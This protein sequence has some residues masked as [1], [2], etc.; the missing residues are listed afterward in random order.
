M[1]KERINNK[2]ENKICNFVGIKACEYEEWKLQFQQIGESY[3]S[4]FNT[5]G[6]RNS[7]SNIFQ[8]IYKCNPNRLENSFISLRCINRAHLLSERLSL[9]EE[10]GYFC[11]MLYIEVTSLMNGIDNLYNMEYEK[12]DDAVFDKMEQDV[13]TCYKDLAN[14]YLTETQKLFERVYPEF[15]EVKEENQELNGKRIKKSIKVNN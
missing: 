9:D 15:V 4:K 2:I 14:F 5:V 10:D 11:Q 7:L 8:R 1:E 12:E 13:F 6:A 3:A